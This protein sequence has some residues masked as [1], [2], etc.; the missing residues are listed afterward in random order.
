[1]RRRT[2]VVA[3]TIWI[4]AMALPAVSDAG[5]AITGTVRSKAGQPLA[6]LVLL[7][8]P[9]LVAAILAPAAALVVSASLVT[10]WPIFRRWG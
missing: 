4:G 9:G 3:V 8:L 7:W 2:L 10:L 6:G 1:M 5:A